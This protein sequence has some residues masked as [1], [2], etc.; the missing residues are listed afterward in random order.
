MEGCLNLALFSSFIIELASTSGWIIDTWF[1][2]TPE[3][4]ELELLLIDIT[5]STIELIRLMFR[6]N[7]KTNKSLKKILNNFGILKN[8]FWLAS[9]F[10]LQKKSVMMTMAW[11]RFRISLIL[12]NTEPLI[13]QETVSADQ[14]EAI[15]M[16]S[17]K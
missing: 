7:L 14:V 13:I 15:T 6:K 12:W 9:S 11:S 3:R 10:G 16:K 8:L 4:F 2:K 17:R 5:Q 1:E